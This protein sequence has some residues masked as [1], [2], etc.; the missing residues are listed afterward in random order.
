MKTPFNLICIVAGTFFVGGG[1]V[2][3]QFILSPVAVT[4]TGM[5]TFAPGTSLTNIINHSGLDAH[6]FTSGVTSFDT[7][8]TP[9]D[10]F[11]Q[12]GDGTK[13][14]SALSFDVVVGN[15]DLDLGASYKIDR[16]AVWNVSVK[17]VKIYVSETMAGLGSASPVGPFTLTQ[18]T[19]PGADGILAD[20]VDLGGVF[21]G[22]YVRLAVLSEYKF[23]PNDSSYYATVSEVAV[24]AQ[25]TSGVV[26]PT[27]S[28][29]R[30]SNGDVTVTFT[31]TLQSKANIQDSFQNVSGNPQSTYTIPKANLTGRQF[32]RSS[33]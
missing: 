32:F 25:P 19:S 24:S 9:N 4:E 11:S 18:N 27:I 30:K 6:P 14:Q 22:R 31:G 1:S 33:N 17:T 8:F 13:W 29:T 20:L 21:Q 10:K 7:Y 26:T 12:N 23:N 28:A 16:L 15:I 3:G 2:I 5:G